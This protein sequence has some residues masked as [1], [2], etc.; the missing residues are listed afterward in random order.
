MT[1]QEAHKKSVN[2]LEKAS[3]KDTHYLVM[4]GTVIGDEVDVAAGVNADPHILAEMLLGAMRDS[5]ETAYAIILAMSEYM[6]T[7]EVN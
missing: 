1:I 7:Q 6:K 5:P 3:N 2:M 4:S